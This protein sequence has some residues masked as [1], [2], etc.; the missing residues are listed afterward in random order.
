VV[1]GATNFGVHT[2][3]HLRCS[4]CGSRSGPLS[5]GSPTMLVGYTMDS[6]TIDGP[7]VAQ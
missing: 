5:K 7:R 2:G 6:V 3:A 4:V 1:A